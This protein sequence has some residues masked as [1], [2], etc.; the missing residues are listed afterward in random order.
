MLDEPGNLMD[1]ALRGAHGGG[2]RA[3]RWSRRTEPRIETV[4]QLLGLERTRRPGRIGASP[5]LVRE[6]ASDPP[7]QNGDRVVLRE[8]G[9]ERR[10]AMAAMYRGRPLDGAMRGARP[11]SVRRRETVEET[12]SFFGA[13]RLFCQWRD[14][15]P[16]VGGAGTTSWS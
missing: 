15:R 3:G 13:G 16:V 7:V 11:S 8:T 14:A 6:G 5:D 1:E 4:R 12:W 9:A 10:A 2:R